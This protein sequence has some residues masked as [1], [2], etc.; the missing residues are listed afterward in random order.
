MSDIG[1]VLNT[2]KQAILS[3]LAAINTT[4]SNIANVNTP[5]YSRLRPVFSTVGAGAGGERDQAGVAISHIERVYDRYLEIQI[6]ESDQDLGYYDTLKSALDRVESMINESSGGGLNDLMSKFWTAWSDLS[7]NP[8]GAAERE[9]LVTVSESLAF[10]FRQQAEELKKIQQD[11]NS[12]LADV[13]EEINSYASEIAV[14][15]ERITAIEVD[16][17]NAGDL[18]DRRTVLLKKI[19]SNVNI[20]SFE[21]KTSGLNVFLS[22]GMA[23]VQGS[24]SWSLSLE[25]SDGD[26]NFFDIYIEGSTETQNSVI[27]SGKMGAYLEMRDSILAGYQDKLNALAENF[28]QKVNSRHRLGYDEDGNQGGDFFNPVSEAADMRVAAA[29]LAD[30]GKIAASATV[31][32]DGDN[33]RMIGA[34]KDETMY[35][36][37]SAV[38]TTNFDSDADI[39]AGSIEI[40][41]INQVFKSTVGAIVL[42][43]GADASTWTVTSD[44]GY[45]DL[46]VLAAASGSLTL[47]LNGSG[48]AGLA[49]ALTGTW[50]QGDTLSF[51]LTLDGRKSTLNEFFGALTAL[52]GQDVSNASRDLERQTAVSNQLIA[53]RES[54]SGVSID[55]EMLNL[56][57]F[58]AAYNA[59]GK[60]VQTLEE[61][62][63]LTISLVD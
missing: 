5:N 63:D 60:L 44:G 2:A 53:Q 34:I 20:Q 23:L 31:H 16:G 15:N 24:S 42:T 11:M 59:A 7:A 21:D 18:R 25:P 43:R 56:M 6:A 49:V 51:N 50:E 57:K 33:A 14:L 9:V 3:E 52:V 36:A 45:T 13:V 19:S 48:E 1:R 62:L 39:P 4:G 29:I 41:A 28:V 10:H 26:R 30:A 38:A 40:T 47:D 55:E 61:M 8:G 58:Q 22:D 27:T 12:T 17:G 35:G 32:G 37:A 54:V 46:S